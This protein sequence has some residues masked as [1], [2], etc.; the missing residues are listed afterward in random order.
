MSRDWGMVIGSDFD[1]VIAD[2]YSLLQAGYDLDSILRDDFDVRVIQPLSSGMI[3][4]LNDN[5]ISAVVTARDVLTPVYKWLSHYAPGYKGII[6]SSKVW[7]DSKALACFI[8]GIDVFID[9]DPVWIEEISNAGIRALHFQR[10]LHEDPCM[11]LKG[12]IEKNKGHVQNNIILKG[13]QKQIEG[14]R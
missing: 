7:N 2:T 13:T 5:R 4:L 1:G 10:H 14:K 6:Q 12:G 9:D 8:H 11:I 3:Q